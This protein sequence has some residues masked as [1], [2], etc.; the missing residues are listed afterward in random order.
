MATATEA[1]TAEATRTDMVE[2]AMVK[3]E[4]TA[5]VREVVIACPTWEPICRSKTGVSSNRILIAHRNS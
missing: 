4:A 3:G 2:E 1:V 5:A